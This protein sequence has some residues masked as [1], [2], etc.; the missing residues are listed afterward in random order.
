MK[1]LLFQIIFS[2]IIEEYLLYNESIPFNWTKIPQFCYIEDFILSNNYR[3]YVD[4]I[5]PMKGCNSDERNKNY[6]TNVG[7]TNITFQ[8]K[9]DFFFPN[10]VFPPPDFDPPTYMTFRINFP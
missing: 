1:I 8:P 10:E 9:L 2:S 7:I 6:A 4:D 3:P 5:Y